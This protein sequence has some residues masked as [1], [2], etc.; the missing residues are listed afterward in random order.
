M[1]FLSVDSLRFDWGWLKALVKE[2]SKTAKYLHGRFVCFQERRRTNPSRGGKSLLREG[3]RGGT[4][5]EATSLFGRLVVDE[6]HGV[7]VF[8]D[9]FDELSLG[10]ALCG[11]EGSRERWTFA[12]VRVIWCGL[13]RSCWN[14]SRIVSMHSMKARRAQAELGI[15]G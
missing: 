4:K 12:L 3:G 10:E 1:T 6:T 11:G 14:H 15:C 7:V 9:P 5:R 2:D 8:D 13:D